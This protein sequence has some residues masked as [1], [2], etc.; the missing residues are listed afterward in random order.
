MKKNC[1]G[2]PEVPKPFF[3]IQENVVQ[4]FRTKFSSL[5]YVMSLASN[6]SYCLLA[7]HNSELRCVICTGVTPFALSLHLIM[8]CT[9]LSQSEWS[10]FFMYFII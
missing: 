8:N 2:E 4:S 7:N 1:V 9:A 6:I 5:F 3:L 10:N